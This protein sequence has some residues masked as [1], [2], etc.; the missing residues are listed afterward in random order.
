MKVL[1]L[2]GSPKGERSNTYRLTGAFLDGLRQVQQAEAEVLAVGKLHLLPCRGCFA[3]WSKTPGKCVLQD[4]MAGVIEKILAA[5]VLIWSFPLYYFGIPGQLK[6]LIDRQLPMSLPFMTDNASGGHPSRYDRSGQRQVVI[7]TC[8]FYTAEGNYDAVD[9][10]FARLC[11]ADGYTAI[12]C[13][14]GELFRVPELRQ[15]TDAYLEHVKQA[16]AEFAR[17]AVTEETAC[18]LRQPL[19]PRAVFEQMADASWGVSREDVAKSGTSQTAKLSPALAFTRQMAALYNPASWNGQDRVLEFFYTD[20]GETYQVVLGKDGQRVLEADFLPCTTRIDTPLSV[21]QQIGSGELNGQQAMMEHL[22]RVTGDFSVMLHWDEIFGLG[23]AASKP[24]AAPRKKTNMTLML[25][26]WMAIWIALSIQAR[27]GACIGLAVCG[28]LPFAFLKYRMT[29]FEPCSMLAVG[30]ICVLTL[31]DALPLTVLL[32][33][34]YLLFGLMWG[35]TVFR[36]L[37]LTAH[38]SMNG[39]GGETA[40]QNPLFLRTNRILTACWAAL[41]LLT[42]IWTGQLMQTSV[43]YLTGAFNSVLPIL[44]GIFTAWFQRWYPA[45]YATSTK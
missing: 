6:L 31:L 29:V 23:A 33:L 45:H 30:S 4:D 18:A 42:P 37:P 13:G 40:L 39:Y 1:V 41:Y 14:Q 12:Y 19:F 17:G 43:S 38:Y 9:A 2:N 15:R 27:A 44:L 28:L 5:D 35:V 32:P 3:C 20:A 24:P 36:P 10:Q 22:Y 26:P 8:G 7:S 11:G 25:L 21:W 34:S 16:G